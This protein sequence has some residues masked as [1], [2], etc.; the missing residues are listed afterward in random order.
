[1]IPNSK[2]PP[3]LGLKTMTENR[4]V[5]D[6]TTDTLYF[7]GSGAVQIIPPPG[8]MSIKLKRGESGH[9][10]I[11]VTNPGKD[12]K[13]TSQFVMFCSGVKDLI[14]M[15]QGEPAPVPQL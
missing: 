1:M 4:G 2:V 6:L 15:V 3:L 9:I 12:K 8:T 7:C 10:F 11:P 13:T 14:G 5:L